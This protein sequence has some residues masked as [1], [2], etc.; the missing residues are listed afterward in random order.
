MEGGVEGLVGVE[1][2]TSILLMVSLVHRGAGEEKGKERAREEGDSEERC[3]W[4]WTYI[5]P[6]PLYT[7]AVGCD[8][9]LRVYV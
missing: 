6:S 9:D 4:T 2:I 7:R 8:D 1:G 5:R 3:I